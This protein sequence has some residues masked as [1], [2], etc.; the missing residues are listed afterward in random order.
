MGEGP[1]VPV[2]W[3]PAPSQELCCLSQ[4]LTQ[5][6]QSLGW[7]A[8]GKGTGLYWRLLSAGCRKTTPGLPQEDSGR[9]AASP[10]A[11]CQAQAQAQAQGKWNVLKCLQRWATLGL[12]DS[13]S[14]PMSSTPALTHTHAYTYSPIYLYVCVH[15]CAHIHTYTHIHIPTPMHAHTHVYT[16]NTRIHILTH[17]P[18]SLHLLP[19]PPLHMHTHMCT[20]TYIY[21]LTYTPTP[22]TTIHAY[23]HTDTHTS[24]IHPC[25]WHVLPP[26]HP[27][28]LLLHMYTRTTHI[29]THAHPPIPTHSPQHPPI[30]IHMHPHLV[31]GLGFC[32]SASGNSDVWPWLEP[33]YTGH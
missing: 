10:E 13:P 22:H 3:T 33:F 17:I 4:F 11:V 1:S 15:T 12:S 27:H 9:M 19:P 8:G 14:G 26:T 7:G 23:T 16:Y 28:N 32:D 20:H 21:M 5:G 31:W 24:V 29:P 6:S 18:T 25:T 30:H 2:S